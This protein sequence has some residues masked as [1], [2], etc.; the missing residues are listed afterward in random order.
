MQLFIKNMVCNRCIKVVKQELSSLGYSIETI[1]LG[2]VEIRDD[3]STKE[4]NQNF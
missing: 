2:K 4:L 1:E 3:L